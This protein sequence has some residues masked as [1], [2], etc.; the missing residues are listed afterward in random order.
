MKVANLQQR[1]RVLQQTL[2]AQ[3][4]LSHSQV[5]STSGL[6]YEKLSDLGSQVPRFVDL[7]AEISS[8]EASASAAK[9][10]S[11]RLAATEASLSR[12]E[13]IATQT[14]ALFVRALGTDA[15]N[16][17]EYHLNEQARA[18]LNDAL[19]VLNT[20]AEGRY[21]FNGLD[22]ER[23]PVGFPDEAVI[24]PSAAEL[25][26]GGSA[27]LAFADGTTA[28]ISWPAGSS[29]ADVAAEAKSTLIQS[30]QVSRFAD[31]YADDTSVRFLGRAEENSP[32][33]LRS[34][35]VA[36]DE[37]LSTVSTRLRHDLS[38]RSLDYCAAP[39]GASYPVRPYG[40]GNAF[41]AGVTAD[42]PAIEKLVRALRMAEQAKMVPSTDRS[43]VSQA[44]ALVAEA[45]DDLGALRG[46]VGLR[47]NEADQAVAGAEEALTFL[48]SSFSDLTEV[49]MAE[50]MSRISQQQLQIEASFMVLSRIGDIT[51]LN[52]LR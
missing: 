35:T 7:S 37:R 38:G 51:L 33:G 21:L 6:R 52:Y 41:A 1:D 45:L 4:N 50:L 23:P 40:S 28:T 39:A 36:G 13:D 9:D 15:A 3:E 20:R 46:K 47:E 27:I 24:M 2:K 29:L 42:E 22:P 5:Q 48:Q 16:T 26:A 14:R 32:G 44:H 43:A 25:A 17:D 31:I 8:L 12:L 10:A 11:R 18:M 34:V 49:D 30:G 19:V